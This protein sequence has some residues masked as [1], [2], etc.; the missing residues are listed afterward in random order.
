MWIDFVNCPDALPVLSH[1]NFSVRMLE[2]LQSQ[3]GL[4]GLLRYMPEGSLIRVHLSTEGLHLTAMKAPKEADLFP[5][6][7]EYSI[8]LGE[9]PIHSVAAYR[10]GRPQRDWTKRAVLFLYAD[11]DNSLLARKGTTKLVVLEL[12]Q[13]ND[14][15]DTS[16]FTLSANFPMTADELAR[17]VPRQPR[18]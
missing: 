12:V 6:G 17:L 1:L 10:A 5:L 13:L 14:L 7:S 11:K 2:Y 18:H 16:R 15:A 3:P 8:D 4:A 9:G